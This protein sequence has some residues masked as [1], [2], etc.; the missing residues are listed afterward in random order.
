MKTRHIKE[1]IHSLLWHYSITC[2]KIMDTNS[3]KYG[4]VEQ[5]T[6]VN[7]V[8]NRNECAKADLEKETAGSELQ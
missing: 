4:Y 2:F 7:S 3:T 5:Y 8:L 1:N 6:Q